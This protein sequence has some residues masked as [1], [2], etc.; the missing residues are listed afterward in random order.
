MES[1]WR[2]SE[3]D[4]AVKIRKVFEH[5]KHGKVKKDQLLIVFLVGILL[6]VISIPA[7]TKKDSN[8]GTKKTLAN[9]SKSS[10]GTTKQSEYT[11]YM[12]ERLERILSQIDGAGQVQVMIT[13]KSDG[14][15][16]VEK[17]RK[18]NE[19]NVSEQDSQGG[20]RTTSSHDTQET[21]VYNSGSSTSGVQEPYVSKELSP[22][23]QGVI[24]IAP[25]GDDAVVVKNI[26]EAVQALFEIDTHKIRILK[27]NQLIIAA[28]AVMIAAAGYLN[29]SGRLLPGSQNTKEAGSDLANKELLDI[30]DEDVA[31]AS[32]DIKSQDGDEG[33]VDGNPGEA[34]LTSGDAQ[35]VAAQAKVT[36]EQV[37]AKNKET[38]QS[39]IDSD[40]LSDAQKQDAVAQMVAMTE[41]AE[42]ETAA[43]TMLASKGFLDS[44]V[45]ISEDSADVVVNASELTEANRAQ[46]EDIVTRKTGVAAQNIVITP[47]Y[48]EGK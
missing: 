37:R 7:G 5:L 39:I 38:L 4:T 46:I 44:V 15:K 32:G 42:K 17:D 19:E 29:Y 28:L 40:S 30:S 21:T 18:S 10:V 33:E 12:E 41:I 20:S 26:T 23:A 22:Q 13:W 8:T 24:V 2:K 6:L 48:A 43:E 14:E 25:G 45:S 3:S 16:V 27:K 36:R 35:A 11:A 9:S 31:S 1:R 47:V 34:V